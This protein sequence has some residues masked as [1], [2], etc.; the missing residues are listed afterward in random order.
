MHRF[1][2]GNM[3]IAREGKPFCPPPRER[4]EK[5]RLDN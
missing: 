4:A 1:L 5:H 2:N 3:I